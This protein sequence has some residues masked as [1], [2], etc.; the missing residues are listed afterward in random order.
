[1]GSNTTKLEQYP[2]NLKGRRGDV[3][4]AI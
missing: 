3:E 2:L 1:V 4:E